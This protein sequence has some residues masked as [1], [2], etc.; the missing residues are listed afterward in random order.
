M[1]DHITGKHDMYPHEQVLMLMQIVSMQCV[2]YLTLCLLVPPL[3]TI[4][5]EPYALAYEG[6]WLTEVV[7]K[8]YNGA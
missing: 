7:T 4:F 5:A 6:K 1:V 3:L 2:H 8:G